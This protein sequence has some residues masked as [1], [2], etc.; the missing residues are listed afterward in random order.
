MTSVLNNA[1]FSEDIAVCSCLRGMYFTCYA[2]LGKTLNKSSF[3]ILTGGGYL[4]PA[5]NNL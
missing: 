4:P 5:K 2:L 3:R 1:K